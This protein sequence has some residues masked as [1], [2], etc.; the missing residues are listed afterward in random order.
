M[1]RLDSRLRKI[2]T[3]NLSG[4]NRALYPLSYKSILDAPLG[5]KPRI[6]PV[7]GGRVNRCTTG[8]YVESS[9]FDPDPRAFQ[10]RASTKLA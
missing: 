8:H 7:K 9:G 10:A 5:F 2:R 6:F 1:Y 3:L 4:R